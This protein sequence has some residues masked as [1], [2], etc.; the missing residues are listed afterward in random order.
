MIEYKSLINGLLI[1]GILIC[2]KFV[3]SWIKKKLLDGRKQL[4]YKI[5]ETY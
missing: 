3:Y 5:F 4:R 1:T 2:I